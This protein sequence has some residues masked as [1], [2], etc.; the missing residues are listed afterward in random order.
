VETA[1]LI[2]LAQANIPADVQELLVRGDPM[3][4]ILPHALVGAYARARA[5]QQGARTNG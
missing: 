5:S 3:R 1:L 2:A 4:G